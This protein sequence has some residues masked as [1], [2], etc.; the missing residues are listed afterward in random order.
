MSDHCLWPQLPDPSHS[1]SIFWSPL[2]SVLIKTISWLFGGSPDVLGHSPEGLSYWLSLPVFCVQPSACEQVSW[3]PE[4]T[5]EIPDTQEMSDW[6]VVGKVGFPEDVPEIV[7]ACL[8]TFL[9]FRS[10]CV[11]VL[12]CE[13]R[14][15]DP[16]GR[17]K[18]VKRAPQGL[19]DVPWEMWQTGFFS[20]Y[21]F[22]L[23]D[24]TKCVTFIFLTDVFQRS[25]LYICVYS[26]HYWAL[27]QVDEK[28]LYLSL[29]S[30]EGVREGICLISFWKML[31]MK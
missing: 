2:G 17:S 20:S 8:L 30:N 1:V 15:S 23:Q 6:M 29:E 11:F 9:L 19:T 10:V 21:S 27:F 4:C 24:N 31:R 5:T 25:L 7:G 12:T 22:N 14:E 26:G 3:F 28:T 18:T 16:S 13:K